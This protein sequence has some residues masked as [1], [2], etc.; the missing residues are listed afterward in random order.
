MDKIRFGLSFMVMMFSI[1]FNTIDAAMLTKAPEPLSE[2]SLTDTDA[3][4]DV[5]AF[6]EDLCRQSY[7]TV[8]NFNKD[9]ELFC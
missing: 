8:K 5:I 3:F 6:R 2:Q 9:S 1:L 4:A 7:S